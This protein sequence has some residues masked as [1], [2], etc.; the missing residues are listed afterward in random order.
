MQPRTLVNLAL[1]ALA[2]GLGALVILRPGE[3]PVPVLRVSELNP[4]EVSTLRFEPRSG[5]AML[6]R[7]VGSGWRLEAPL[8]LRGNPIRL[9]SLTTVARATSTAGFRAAGNDPSQYG[10]DPP[11]ARLW[12]D[13]HEFSFGDTES[14]DR[15]R[16]VM[17][18]GQVHLVQDS[19]FQHL[20]ADPANFVHPAP[21][22]PGATI[23]GI[24]VGGSSLEYRH[25]RWSSTGPGRI[26]GAER[27]GEIAAAWSAASAIR[28]MPYDPGLAWAESVRLVIG[29]RSEPLELGIARSEFELILGRADAGV[30]YHFFR[31]LE[32]DL[33][34]SDQP[35]P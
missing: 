1:V 6:A 27:A 17:H 12:L 35:A 22:R 16:Y 20:S 25:G 26:V 4:A 8:E 28:T 9:A 14:L 3:A 23:L 15:R 31:R 13:E 5:A 30:Q 34:G 7:R 32:R 2:I 24:S 29:D 10:L 11:R 33:L 21:V 18:D 19:Y